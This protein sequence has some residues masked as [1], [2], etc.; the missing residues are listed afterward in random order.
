M[1]TH[2]RSGYVTIFGLPNAGKSTLMNAL[3]DVKLSITSPRPQTTRRRVLGILNKPEFQAVFLDTPGI[4]RPKYQLQEKMMTIL[5]ASISDADLL[6]L[7][8]D[9]T[10]KIHPLG[11]DLKDIN[12]SGKPLILVL[13]KIDV[14]EKNT[15]LPIIDIYRQWYPFKTIIPI[16]AKDRDGL[17]LVE[18]NIQANLPLN[19]PYYPTDI[20]SDHPERFFVAEIIREHIFNEFQ[21]EIPYST[22]VQVD[23]FK[24]REKGK[25]FISATIYVE[26]PSQKGILI[27]NKGAAIKRIS[28]HAREQI[29]AFLERKIYLQIFVKVSE[30]WR[31]DE[32]KLKRLGY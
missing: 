31:K 12:K 17:N 4:L 11:I 14:V 2:F 10:R 24:E 30:N 19:P 23:T 9:I 1:N 16:S 26:R 21:Q 32:N 18:T 13:N 27:G 15:I 7:I 3:L 22:E 29:E 28:M 20:I 25:D 8:S 6:L 5:R